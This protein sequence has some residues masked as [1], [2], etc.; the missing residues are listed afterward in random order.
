MEG[1]EEIFWCWFHKGCYVDDYLA[2]LCISLSVLLN[3]LIPE[4]MSFLFSS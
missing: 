1:K 2:W 3:I 4:F